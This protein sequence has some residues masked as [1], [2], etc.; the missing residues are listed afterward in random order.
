[1]SS[2]TFLAVNISL[3]RMARNCSAQDQPV[4]AWCCWPFHPTCPNVRTSF[5]TWLPLFS[6]KEEGPSRSPSW[7]KAVYLAVFLHTSTLELISLIT[8]KLH[9]QLLNFQGQTATLL[10]HILDLHHIIIEHL[11]LIDDGGQADHQ[12]VGAYRVW[13]RSSLAVKFLLIHC[14]PITQAAECQNDSEFKK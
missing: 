14:P 3:K 7:D 8:I 4:T 1:M 13:P 10:F 2:I 12:P 6:K 9:G 5:I 11:P